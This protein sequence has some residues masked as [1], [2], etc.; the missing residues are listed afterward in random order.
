[1]TGDAPDAL[2]L[3]AAE[4]GAVAFFHKPFELSDLDSIIEL[5]S[6]PSRIGSHEWPAVIRI[7]LLD[8]MLQSDALYSVFQPIIEL[9][10]GERIGFE[11]LTRYL[12]DGPMRNPEILFQYAEKK[13]RLHD[14]EM[15]CMQSSLRSGA[16]LPPDGLI[17]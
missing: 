4:R 1:M 13:H 2:Q 14:L 3:E 7:P 9:M 15:T 5:M 16:A 10:T 6:Q 17:F 11:A 8:H 12:S